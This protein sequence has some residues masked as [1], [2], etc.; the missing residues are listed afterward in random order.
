MVIL[1]HDNFYQQSFL[2][3]GKI[4]ESN[5]NKGKGICVFY[6]SEIFY[7]LILYYLRP[8]SNIKTFVYHLY[9][10]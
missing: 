9:T 3:F 1:L 6:E 5:L 10:I 8:L 2:L 7:C 4:F